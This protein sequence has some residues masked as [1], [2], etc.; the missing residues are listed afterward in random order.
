MINKIK[1]L[2]VGLCCEV[3]K[4]GGEKRNRRSVINKEVRFLEKERATVTIYQNQ[5]L[6]QLC[7]H[8]QEQF[9]YESFF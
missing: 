7:S 3:S 4:F 8:Q 6:E 5:N 2:E 1:I 9:I